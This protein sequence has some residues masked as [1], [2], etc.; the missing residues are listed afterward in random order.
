MVFKIKLNYNNSNKFN[1]RNLKK[2]FKV[3]IPIIMR[4]KLKAWKIYSKHYKSPW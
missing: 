4:P 2:F 1:P 3:R